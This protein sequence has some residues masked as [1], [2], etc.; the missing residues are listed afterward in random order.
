MY[1]ILY[2]SI[3]ILMYFQEGSEVKTRIKWSKLLLTIAFLLY[4]NCNEQI[5]ELLG[6]YFLLLL[7][8][9]KD[10]YHLIPC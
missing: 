6:T 9:I 8:G 4:L 3:S 1:S 2:F 7:F 10:I 5:G